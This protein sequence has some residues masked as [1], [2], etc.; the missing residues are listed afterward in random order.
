MS[1]AGTHVGGDGGDIGEEDGQVKEGRRQEQSQGTHERV[2]L[3]RSS[4][5]HSAQLDTT[6]HAQHTCHTGDG[7]EDRSG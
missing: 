3:R 4:P 7:P 5:Q 6:G 1:E 2:S